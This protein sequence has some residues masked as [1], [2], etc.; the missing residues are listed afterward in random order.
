MKPDWVKKKCIALE[1]DEIDLIKL[2]LNWT[3]IGNPIAAEVAKGLK[4]KLDKL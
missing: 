2:L 3:P 4:E 1:Q